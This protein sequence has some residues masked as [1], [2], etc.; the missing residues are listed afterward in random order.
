LDLGIIPIPGLENVTA[1]EIIPLVNYDNV[2]A[3]KVYVK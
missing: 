1:D 3:I 2:N